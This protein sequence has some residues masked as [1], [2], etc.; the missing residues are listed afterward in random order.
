M[1]SCVTDYF[2]VFQHFPILLFEEA[3]SKTEAPWCK[4]NDR[5]NRAEL[6][7]LGWSGIRPLVSEVNVV[8]NVG[9][10]LPQNV[11]RCDKLKNAV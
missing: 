11:P 2:T 7:I 4:V 6:A 5:T 9:G 1:H 3:A 10:L 8:Q